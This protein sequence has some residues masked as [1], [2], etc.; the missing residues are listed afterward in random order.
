MLS[1]ASGG[2]D[3]GLALSCSLHVFSGARAWSEDGFLR[4]VRHEHCV[5][6]CFHEP[7]PSSELAVSFPSPG[8]GVDRTGE[9]SP[10]TLTPSPALCPTSHA[11]AIHI[12]TS[13]LL[14]HRRSPTSH[15]ACNYDPLSTLLSRPSTFLL[16]SFSFRFPPLAPVPLVP[17]TAR[18]YIRARSTFAASIDP[19]S[20]KRTSHSRPPSR[21]S[22]PRA[23]NQRARF[24]AGLSRLPIALPDAA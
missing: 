5:C 10:Q 22:P 14:A 12:S 15:R 6:M 7:S 19:H 24:R 3:L 11:Y 20:G 17:E 8:L 18:R 1:R 13:T 16:C 23:R 9:D 2:S 21:T 4:A